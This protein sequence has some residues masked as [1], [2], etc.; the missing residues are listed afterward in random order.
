MI[1]RGVLSL[2]KIA[3]IGQKGMPGVLGGVEKHVEDLSIRLAA[4]GHEILVYTRP[5][6]VAPTLEEH[7]GVKLVSLPS[8]ATKHLD[9]ITHTF[10]CVVNV[11]FIQ[12][13]DVVHFHAIGPSSMLLLIKLFKPRLA[14]VVTV[15]SRDYLHDKWGSLAQWYLKFGEWVTCKFANKVIVVSQ[16][17]RKF[18][19]ERFGR[20]SIAIPNGVDIVSRLPANQIASEWL[21]SA[22]GYILFV[23]RLI[24][25]KC[26]HDLV[27]AYNELVTDKKLV[28]VGGGSYSDNYID[29]LKKLAGNNPNIIFTGVQTGAILQELYSNAYLFVL[30]SEREGLS[31]ALLE[32]MA[33]EK[34]VVV[35]DIAE[36]REVAQDIGF[37]FKQGNSNDLARV[38]RDLIDRPDIVAQRGVAGKQHVADNYSWGGIVSRTIE[39]YQSAVNE[40][41]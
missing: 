23:G 38:L 26:V 4:E 12:K 19:R 15:H 39:T 22:D 24:R 32:A 1:N 27:N 41:R 14:V 34:T 20:D 37:E 30:P 11:I 29:E 10:F 25:T 33:Y 18:L 31:V 6:Y 35:S 21:L 40:K 3:F 8:V 28:I 17:L 5:K 13:V 9:A 2:V 36:N 7:N 16:G